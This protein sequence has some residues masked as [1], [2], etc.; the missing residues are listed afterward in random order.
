MS[1]VAHDRAAQVVHV[2][3]GDRQADGDERSCVECGRVICAVCRVQ[4]TFEDYCETCVREH[5]Q[6]RYDL[7][8]DD[9]WRD[10]VNDAYNQPST[11]WK[12]WKRS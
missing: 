8:R 3:H 12:Y 2:L 10:H 7:E 6:A 4:Y 11:V 5:E 9:D 1:D